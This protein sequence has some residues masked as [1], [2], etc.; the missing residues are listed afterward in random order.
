MMYKKLPCP[1]CNGEHLYNYRLCIYA[2]CGGTGFIWIEISNAGTDRLLNDIMKGID[3][4][5]I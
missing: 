2:P 4:E 3:C 1:T 5:I